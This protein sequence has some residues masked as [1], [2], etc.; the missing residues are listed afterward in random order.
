MLRIEA[1]MK[2]MT[3]KSG[4]DAPKK[5]NVIVEL[6]GGK[7]K[8]DLTARIVYIDE[9]R[10]DVFDWEGFAEDSAAVIAEIEGLD[11]DELAELMLEIS[12][13]IP[14]KVTSR[15]LSRIR[16]ISR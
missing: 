1:I 10:V 2:R 9:E 14:L 8:A 5:P 4:D 13:G 3:R 16:E 7:L 6:D 12:A 15:D 11:E